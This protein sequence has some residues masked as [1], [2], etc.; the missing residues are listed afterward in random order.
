MSADGHGRYGRGAFA[1]V[2]ALAMLLTAGL[3]WCEIEPCIFELRE[4]PVARPISEDIYGC[5][6]ALRGRLTN[7]C[8]PL[9]RWGGNTAETYNWKLADA[10]N[11]GSDWYFENVGVERHAWQGFL[12]GASKAGARAFVNLPLIGFVAKDKVSH[13]FSVQK[14]G[15]QKSRDPNRPD[16]GDGLRPSGEA[17]VGN[18][19]GDVVIVAD[20]NFVAGWVTAMRDQFPE[21]VRGRRL[22]VALGNEPMLWNRTHRALHP[23]PVS[24]DE[25]WEKYRAMAQAVRRA[26]PEAALAGPELWGWPAC[27]ESALDR[28]THSQGDLRRHGGEA[29]LPWFLDQVRAHEARTGE[30]L[31]DYL[32]VHFYPQAAGVYSASV[33]DRARAWRMET[34]RL[35]N[36]PYYRDPSW[37]AR[38]I[39]LIP[40]LKQMAREHCPGIKVGLT[41]YNWGAEQDISGGL[42]LAIVLGIFGREGLD[43]ACYW[44]APAADS[45]AAHAYAL[46]RNVDGAG[47]RFGDASLDVRCTTSAPDSLRVFAARELSSG[48]L[49]VMA[50]NAGGLPRRLHLLAR[51]IDCAGARGYELSSSASGLHAP[52]VAA[53][54]LE[55]GVELVAPVR[56]ATHW[57]FTVNP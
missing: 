30:R 42:A 49:T 31:L 36:D 39:A 33:E 28:E 38:P 12:T 44:T 25:Y 18:D 10:W 11:T 53:R 51:G 48:A 27:S 24:Y 9:I 7:S 35:L 32:T 6:G 17:L 1:G 4:P 26:V 29:F 14:Y 21:L 55:N 20:T 47:G 2:V 23:Q 50:I 8:I 13:A 41:E 22:I 34:P 45:P 3:A 16:A 56:S 37:I 15:P 19:P 43:L 40:W 5:A 57:R 52:E 46:Y 54:Q